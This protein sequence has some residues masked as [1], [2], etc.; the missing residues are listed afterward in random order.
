L[1]LKRIK[2]VYNNQPLLDQENSKKIIPNLEGPKTTLQ[3]EFN[4]ENIYKLLTKQNPVRKNR[5]I[6]NKNKKAPGSRF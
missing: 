4:L 1:K 5:E 2:E 3:A 6:K